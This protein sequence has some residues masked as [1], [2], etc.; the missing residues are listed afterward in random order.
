M[1]DA[2][3]GSFAGSSGW[4]EVE[5]REHCWWVSFGRLVLSVGPP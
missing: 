5:Y 4:D 3:C 1:I 2:M